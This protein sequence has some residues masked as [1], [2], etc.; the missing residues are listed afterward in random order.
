MLIALVLSC[1]TRV[2]CGCVT[3]GIECCS[4]TPV[5]FPLF[6]VMPLF[7]AVADMTYWGP[8]CH[9]ALWRF[10]H[11]FCC[12]GVWMP[13]WTLFP[14]GQG[15]GYLN[16]LNKYNSIVVLIALALSCMTCDV[17]ACVAVVLSL[18]AHPHCFPSFNI[19]NVCKCLKTSSMTWSNIWPTHGSCFWFLKFYKMFSSASVV[20]RV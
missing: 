1:M 9:D 8:P 11:S 3:V 10:P 6:Q 17:C 18:L 20:S 5:V 16:G 2:V 19:S 12:L 13:Q 4:L 14:V 15:N 7:N